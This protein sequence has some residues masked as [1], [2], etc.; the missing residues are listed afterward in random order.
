MYRAKRGSGRLL[1]SLWG[2]FI[3]ALGFGGI[4]MELIQESV[5]HFSEATKTYFVCEAYGTF[6]EQLLWN[7]LWS[8]LSL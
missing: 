8:L 1:W 6:V 3:L 7:V 5:R 4:H 2:R